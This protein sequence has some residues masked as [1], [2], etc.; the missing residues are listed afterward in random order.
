MA[1]DDL[2]TNAE[3]KLIDL[4]SDSRV[5]E[6]IYS[7]DTVVNVLEFIKNIKGYQFT[8]APESRIGDPT[9]KHYGFLV[10]QLRDDLID[11]KGPNFNADHQNCNEIAKSMVRTNRTKFKFGGNS[12][13]QTV[14]SFSYSE[15]TPFI[16]EAVKAVDVKVDNLPVV[17]SDIFVE[18]GNYNS[19]NKEIVLTL[20]NGNDINIPATDLLDNTVL[21]SSILNL[22]FQIHIHPLLP[23]MI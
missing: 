1:G 23:M 12:Q 3:G 18:S 8:W 5:K 2:G 11:P 14:E 15:L 9:K 19:T 16:I 7:L 4:P 13:S 17:G 20:N 6:N 21:K 22:L 10:D